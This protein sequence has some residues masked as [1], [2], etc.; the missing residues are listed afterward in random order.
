MH[1][2]EPI[3]WAKEHIYPLEE[4]ADCLGLAAF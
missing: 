4:R 1:G 3:A 2:N